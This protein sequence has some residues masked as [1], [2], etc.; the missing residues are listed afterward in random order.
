MYTFVLFRH[1]DIRQENTGKKI[2]KLRKDLHVQHLGNMP[3]IR[4]TQPKSETCIK[5]RQRQH[6]CFQR[7]QLVDT[8]V[9]TVYD[10]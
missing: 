4:K 10:S 8:V 1:A 6:K 9:A 3:Q 5:H 7:T 2:S